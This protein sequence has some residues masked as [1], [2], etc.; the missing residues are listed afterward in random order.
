MIKRIASDKK[1]C[2]FLQMGARY[3]LV[4][5][6]FVLVFQVGLRKGQKRALET[7]E[8]WY[9]QEQGRLALEDID[10]RSMLASH[11]LSMVP[12]SFQ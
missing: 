1:L 10:S 8:S 5:L 11:R 3:L 4:L 6:S 7:Y 12:T 9:Q 2:W